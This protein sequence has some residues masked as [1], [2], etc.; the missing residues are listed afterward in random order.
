MGTDEL[1]DS[2][3]CVEP[4]LS[5]QQRRETVSPDDGGSGGA[6]Y[7]G[8]HCDDC[9]ALARRGHA[10]PLCLS[11]FHSRRERSFLS[12]SVFVAESRRPGMAKGGW[13]VLEIYLPNSRWGSAMLGGF[14][15]AIF[16]SVLSWFSI[17][18][19]G[20][21]G[22][23]LFLAIPFFM[24]YLGAW[25]YCY[26][27]PRSFGECCSVA[28][29]SVFLAGLIIVGIAFEGIFCV[30]MAAPIALPLALLG[31]YLAFKMQEA[32]YLQPQPHT[33]LS[34]LLVIPLLAGAE[35]WAPAPTPRF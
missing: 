27:A 13:G 18:L 8:G 15:G 21:Y 28:L 17:S 34:L 11:V 12:A 2:P 4:A 1:H 14:A 24:G 7:L 33:M 25:L 22:F 35:F 19:L 3:E 32:R 6:F 23:T 20:G 5:S 29:A 26:R 9:E 10:E 31:A 30:A 16:G